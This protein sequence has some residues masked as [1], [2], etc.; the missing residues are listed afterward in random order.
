MNWWPFARKCDNCERLFT[1][2]SLEREARK[3]AEDR[4]FSIFTTPQTPPD[5][6]PAGGVMTW[7]HIVSD[8]NR[9]RDDESSGN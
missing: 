9:R 5:K 6:A 3:I 1:L 2:L 7:G 4:L 8:L